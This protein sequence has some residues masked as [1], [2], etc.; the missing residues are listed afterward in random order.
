MRLK[1]LIFFVARNK[2]LHL[3]LGMV[4][5]FS[6][7]NEVWDTL[8]E[9]LVSGNFHSA[10]GVVMVGLWHFLQSISE[11]IESADYLKEGLE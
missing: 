9:D 1:E 5:V 10:H 6:G 8:A 4:V 2:W 3:F 7:L 11:I